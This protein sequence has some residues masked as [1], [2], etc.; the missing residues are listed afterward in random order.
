M[1]VSIFMILL[2]ILFFV[3]YNSFNSKENE[4]TKEKSKYNKL[5]IKYISRYINIGYI[6][7]YL[8]HLLLIALYVGI[9]NIEY[10]YIYLILF[11]IDILSFSLLEFKF[12][13]KKYKFK[14][15]DKKIMDD[16]SIL[17]V[18]A[19]YLLFI[20]EKVLMNYKT[21]GDRALDKHNFLINYHLIL[22]VICVLIIIYS[23]RYLF[24]II[25]KNKEICTYTY[26][27]ELYLEDVNF[28]NRIDIK[29]GFNH[30]IYLAS[31]I[32]F[33]Y[34]NIP[35]IY[36]LYILLSLFL[37]YLI[38]KKIKT[39]KYESDKLN[40][41]IAFTNEKPGII[42]AFMFNKDILLLKKMC[43]VTFM[44]VFSTITYYGLG[45]SIFSY[46]TIGIYFIL[47][48]TIIEDKVYLIRYISSLNESFIDDKI[49]TINENKKINYIDTIKIF[50]ISLY[51]LIIT[52]TIT[53]ESN[54][55]LYDPEYKIEDINIRI[56]KSNIDDYITIESSIYEE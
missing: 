20:I 37:I 47:L 15:I 38:S 17:L 42:Y 51:K 28:Y 8:I 16:R 31:Y 9:T 41:K 12:K 54:I 43:I 21:V 53:Y 39:I 50:N 27:R 35:F 7:L 32:V 11:G 26:N 14:I 18:I 55:V 29:K 2:N 34:I 23:F 13:S 40:K 44:L 56:N 52:D 1:F 30:I 25:I 4:Y 33:F 36:V 19:F 22:R 6:L 10:F 3:L 24:K 5:K 46:T 45:E 48:Y 49:Y